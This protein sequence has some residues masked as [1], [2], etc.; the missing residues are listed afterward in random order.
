MHTIAERFVT[1]LAAAAQSNP[2]A[3]F[4]RN[5]IRADDG[6]ASPHPIWSAETGRAVFY[7]DY[8]RFEFRLNNISVFVPDYETT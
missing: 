2:V 4:I 1:A 7:Q 3:D 5:T 8:R 6:D